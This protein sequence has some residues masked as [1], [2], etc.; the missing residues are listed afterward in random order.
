MLTILKSQAPSL[1]KQ[2]D[3]ENSNAPI[4]IENGV[5]HSVVVK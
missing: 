2:D 4:A 5:V 3:M 1:V